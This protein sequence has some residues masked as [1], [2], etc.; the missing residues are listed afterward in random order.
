MAFELLRANYANTSTQFVVNDNTATAVNVLIRDTRFQYASSTFA[1]DAT[2]V[3]MRISFNE[4]LTVDRIALVSH[5][6]KSFT[7]FYNGATANTFSITGGDTTVSN[8]TTNSTT[9]HY[10]RCA[11]V[12]VTSVSIDMKSTIVANKNKTIGFLAISEMLTDF[13]G[14]IPSAQSF[15]PSLKPEN[16]VHTLSDGRKRI[17]TVGQVWEASFQLDFVTESIR[18]DLKEIFDDA[19]PM[20]FCPFGTTTGWDET[21]FQCVWSDSFDFFQYS[22]NASDAG[23]SGG[24]KLFEST[25]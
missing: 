20:L 9:S 5:N 7:L 21:I 17:Q 24:I 2:T 13:G 6:L 11:S 3:T 18:D 23:F 15:K 22:D 1:N 8:Y 4:T 10:F 25:L 14:R 19:L 16:I 12:G